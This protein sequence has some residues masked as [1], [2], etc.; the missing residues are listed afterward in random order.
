MWRRNS[1]CDS[2][3]VY[4]LPAAPAVTLDPPRQRAAQAVGERY[5]RRTQQTQKRSKPADPT[6]SAVP[7]GPT[8]ER[9]TRAKPLVEWV[10]KPRKLLSGGG[11]LASTVL[12]YLRF[13]Q[14]LLNNGELDGA[15]I[16]SPQAV[17]AM[18]ADAMP[19]GVHFA[20]SLVGPKFGTSW[21][22]G[23]K[24]EPIRLRAMRLV[25]SAASAGA[26]HGGPI[27]GSILRR[28]WS[29]FK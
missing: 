20:G 8:V 1:K 5:R 7:L 15:R 3:G 4:E 23:S 9:I 27:S 21:G 19:S 2:P 24:S 18:T 6:H 22:L 12:D 28:R 13:C 16:L 26:E 14:M 10:S 17:A 11:G 25:L 29:S